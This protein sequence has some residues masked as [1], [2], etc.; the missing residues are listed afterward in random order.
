MS[1]TLLGRIMALSR[2]SGLCS[3]VHGCP[4]GDSLHR[5][6][7]TVRWCGLV[8]LLVVN[9]AGAQIPRR[10]APGDFLHDLAGVI[11]ES[12]QEK[13]RQLQ[14][15][16]FQS[17]QVPIVVVTL[18]RMDPYFPG[19]PN[20]ETL[21]TT[22]FNRWGIGSR[23]KND[24]ILVLVS[25]GD[26][27]GRIEL[28]ADWGRKWDRYAERI[29]ANEMV[30]RFKQGRY[31]AGLQAAVVKL[32]EMARSGPNADVPAPGAFE[33]LRGMARFANQNNPIAERLG[34]YAPPLMIVAGIGCF[35]A[36]VFFPDRRST[37]IIA[38]VAL[39]GLALLFWVV[40]IFLM[41]IGRGRS[42]SSSGGSGGFGGG[43][44]GGGGASGSW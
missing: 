36:A 39:I 3:V 40:M 11:S 35:V 42:G 1:E 19:V 23:Q 25:T 7:K 17:I 38:G 32:T 10:P 2:D 34:A 31:G 24:G 12:D 41:L 28:G 44:S 6:I 16:T 4:R 30:P 9:S 22:W 21:A 43:F 18:N 29:M 8:A 20:I 26:R 14:Q 15:E 37:L 33:Q 13:I 27:K 5:A